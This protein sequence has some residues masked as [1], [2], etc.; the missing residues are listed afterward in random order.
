MIEKLCSHFTWLW[1]KH[2][3]SGTF[4]P[5]L[6]ISVTQRDDAG[7]RTLQ[8]NRSPLDNSGTIYSASNQNTSLHP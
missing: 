4:Q 2:A 7:S 6:P 3:V 8:T 5:Q 1:R